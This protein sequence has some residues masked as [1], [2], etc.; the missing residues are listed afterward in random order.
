MKRALLALGAAFAALILGVTGCGGDTGPK[1]TSEPGPAKVATPSAQP[2]ET[3]TGVPEAG[4]TDPNER[5]LVRRQPVEQGDASAVQNAKP[6][7]MK[8]ENLLEPNDS[9]ELASLLM[10]LE[11]VGH[12]V[13]DPDAGT[14]VVTIDE[15][16]T[17][18]DKVL[19]HLASTGKFSGK[20]VE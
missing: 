7:R 19:A 2:G 10:G 15:S 4:K 14:V 16:K 17:D 13:V 8:V 9:K 18:A 5:T 6:I 11:G 20:R 12:V 1:Q 3:P